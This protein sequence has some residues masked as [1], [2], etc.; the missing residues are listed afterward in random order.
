MKTVILQSAEE[1]LAEGWHFYE[2][3]EAGAGDYFLSEALASIRGLS[4]TCS[5]HPARG[6]FR[7]MLLKKF[8]CGVY[9]TVTAE[10]ILIYRILDLRRDPK[11][12][13]Q[14]LKRSL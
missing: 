4:N 2:D 14:Q 6:I 8:H 11:W 10:N 1:D 5:L 7:R 13:R 3:Q 9:Y 12:L